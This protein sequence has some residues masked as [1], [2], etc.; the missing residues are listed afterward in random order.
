MSPDFK[1]VEFL[2][3]FIGRIGNLRL[4]FCGN[5]FVMSVFVSGSFNFI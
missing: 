1:T 2:I 3:L 5:L 4:G